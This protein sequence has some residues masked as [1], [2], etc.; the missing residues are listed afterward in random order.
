MY[1]HKNHDVNTNLIIIIVCEKL[2][3]NNCM[4]FMC[5]NTNVIRIMQKPDYNNDMCR[6]LIIIMICAEAFYVYNN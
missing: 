2:H 3:Y 1:T 4:C 5:T 6:S